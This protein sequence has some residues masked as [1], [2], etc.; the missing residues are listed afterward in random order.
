[1]KKNLILVLA[2]IALVAM[3]I[4]ASA[5]TLTLSGKYTAD[6]TYDWTTANTEFWSPTTLAGASKL[7]LNLTFKE[8]DAITAYLPLTVKPFIGAFAPT[9]GSWYFA[10]D[11][12]PAKFWVS[13]GDSYNA[14]KF[15]S[16][17]DPL[18]IA[19][20]LYNGPTVVGNVSGS[21]CGV[22]FNVYAADLG[23][24]T[25]ALGTWNDGNAVLSRLTYGLPAGFTLGVV[26]T[27]NDGVQLTSGDPA[28]T[29]PMMDDITAGVDVTGKLPVVGGNL[30]LAGAGFWRFDEGT[31][32]FVA[33][34]DN[35]Y[36]ML[37]KVE[38]LTLG[39]VTAKL[40]YTSVGDDFVAFF[41]S[42]S[43]TT[44]PLL[45]KYAE[46][47]AVEAEVKAT[48]PVVIPVNLTI[49]DTLWMKSNGNKPVYNETTGKVEVDPI[50]DLKVTVSGAYKADLDDDAATDLV[51]YKVRG[52][53]SYK[54]F[55]LEL[56]PYVYY[57][58][59]SYATPGVHGTATKPADTVFGADITGSPIGGLEVTLGGS[60]E[61]ELKAADLKAWGIYTTEFAPAVVKSAITKV[62][63]FASF[64]K[65]DAADAT[66]NLY[67]FA[68]STVVVNDKL[69]GKVGLLTK[70]AANKIVA[71]ATLN[72]KISDKL[73]A[74]GTYTYRQN[75]IAPDADHADEWRPLGNNHWVKAG[76][77]GTVGASTIS[78][79]YG[80]NGLADADD[81]GFHAGKPWAY[82]RNTPDFMNWQ[83]W[84]VNLAVPF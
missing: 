31:K 55:G 16:L 75:A 46:A 74:F 23:S 13:K 6:F 51:G 28:V 14:K 78:V 15:A 41:K 19:A 35:P 57:L 67:A 33:G 27:F 59:N 10:Y 52:D 44:V 36:A 11:A 66:T 32:K 77:T 12:A 76:V 25:N 29:E 63:A 70:D 53:V 21:L 60:Y 82:L 26:S 48:L 42:T 18:G 30:T 83:L 49:G 64:N 40:S 73:A 9:V 56:K 81:E 80:K 1:M 3:A 47:A 58:N 68:G 65:V 54:A 4:P 34:G 20:K 5:A 61:L 17:G 62:A 7:A 84:T 37:A 38:D 43:T 69:D 22:G 72:Y 24:H 79:A 71:S 39:P 8:G 2:T 50:K 45:T